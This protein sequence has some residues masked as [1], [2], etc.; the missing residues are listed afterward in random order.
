MTVLLDT[1][2]LL[3]LSFA[4]DRLGK[5]SRRLIERARGD[6]TLVVSAISFWETALLVN[7][8]RVELNDSPLAW[9]RAVLNLGIREVP[10]DGFVAVE[11]VSLM[12][13]H[14][15]PADRFILAT[16]IHEDATLITADQR[17]LD[18][19]STLARQDASR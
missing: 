19:P 18:W 3:W 12:P 16:A 10:L 2:A 11:A 4:P 17:M 7:K 1:N 13:L 5:A 15:D 8:G 6:Q 14:S 9:R